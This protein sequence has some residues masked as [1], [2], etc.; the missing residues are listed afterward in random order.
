MSKGKKFFPARGHDARTVK[1][2]LK[3]EDKNRKIAGFAES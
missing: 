2:E 1:S 3:R